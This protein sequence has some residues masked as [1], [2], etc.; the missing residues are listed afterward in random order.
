MTHARTAT[1]KRST[2]E[3]KVEMSLN[4][5]GS[6]TA[7]INTGIGFLDHMLTLF[8]RHSVMD[9]EVRVKGDLEV[10]FH[11][12][13][14]DT[15]IVLGQCLK[16]ALG[17]KKGIRR[18]GWFLLP[19]DESLA[20]VA[21]DFSG[22]PYLVFEVPP[23]PIDPIGGNFSFTLV[24]EFFRGLAFSASMNLHMKVE[25]GRDAHHMAEALFK[26]AARAI[27]AAVRYDDRIAGQIPSTKEAL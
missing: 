27:D 11:H 22:R 4:L 20:R 21:V 16:E 8:A 12:T 14:E 10:D 15:G 25:Y 23:G 26:G 5:D 19:M 9:L 2:A 1:I 7:K 3:T 24:E 13:V 6:G 18:Y 17:D